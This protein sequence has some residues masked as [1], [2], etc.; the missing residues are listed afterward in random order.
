MATTDAELVGRALAGSEP[1]YRELVGRHERAVFGLIARMVRDPGRAEELAQD[2]FVKA[3]TH[4]QTYDASRKFSSWLLKIAHHTAIDELR[5]GA[6]DALP[7]EAAAESA[8]GQSLTG[9][10]VATPAESAE[11]AELARAIE[12]AIGR[13]RAEYRELVVLRYQQDFS[14]EE[15]AEVTGLPLGTIKSYLHR[16]RKEL[17]EHLIAAGWG[18]QR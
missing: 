16:A 15:I 7:L 12:T 11:R 3:F 17:A 2:T 6:F 14:H 5:R 8:G 9:A 13:L 10:H 4:L 1:A 18:G